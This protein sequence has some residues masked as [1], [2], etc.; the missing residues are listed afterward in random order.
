MTEPDVIRIVHTR[1]EGTLIEGSTKGDGVWDIVR[2]HGFRFSRHVGLY[3]RNSRD[4]TANRSRINAAADALRDAGFT[5]EV[6]IDDTTPGRSFADAEAER[7]QRAEERADRYGRRASRNTAAGEARWQRTRGRMAAVPPGQPILAGHHS[8]RGHRR[9]LDWADNQDRKAVGE[10]RKG[11]YWAER[12]QAASDHQKHRESVGTTRRRIDRLEADRRRIVRRLEEGWTRE[13]APDATLP[14]GAEVLDT[15]PDGSRVCRVLPTGDAKAVREA[16][17]AQLDDEIA[18]WRGVLAEAEQRGVKLWS[19]DD[20]TKGDFVIYH[21]T[22]VEV[23]RVNAKTLTI[24]W[25]HYWVASGLAV[26]TVEHA[27]K[28]HISGGRIYTGKVPYDEVQGRI[29]R[30]ELDG[31]NA[32][33]V[34]AL[35]K[36]RI[37]EA[38]GLPAEPVESAGQ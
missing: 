8:E 11:K 19:R 33:Q 22:A 14:D 15:Y 5:V 18:Y 23:I 13:Y 24:P 21:E 9:L 16:D 27:E 17:L 4:K 3:I 10:M 35:I 28:V 32:G 37:R 6:D 2:N 1:A 29:T 7:T 12:A 26:V 31:L 20:F 36:Q 38:K 30:V 25:G 34:R